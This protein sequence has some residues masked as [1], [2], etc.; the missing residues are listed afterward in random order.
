DF[1]W[2]GGN[3]LRIQHVTAAVTQHRKTGEMVWFNQIQLW[4]LDCLDAATRESLLAV[5]REK[6]LPRNC[7]YGDGSP[8]EHSYIEHISKVCRDTAATFRWNERD[9]LMV[10]NMLI[11]HARNPYVGAR[12]I[13]VAM[14]EMA[15]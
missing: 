11:A 2:K 10:D 14:G 3:G 9:L 12:K 4:H 1:E 5:F 15:K 6:D 7:Y 8:I 13:V